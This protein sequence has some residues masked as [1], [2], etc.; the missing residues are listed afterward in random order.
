M[1]CCGSHAAF[2]AAPR[3]SLVQGRPIAG[4]VVLGRIVAGALLLGQCSLAAL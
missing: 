2:G 3:G 4:F 1:V